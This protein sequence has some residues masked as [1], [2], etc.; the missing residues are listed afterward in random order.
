MKAL[1]IFLALAISLASEARQ[2]ECSGQGITFLVSGTGD[3]LILSLGGEVAPADG[4]LS[5]D[6]VDLIAATRT[7]GELTL[8]AKLGKTSPENYLFF[9]GQR[10]SIYCR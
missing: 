4:L 2:V 7:L 9:R 6:E 1:F 3:K 5:A 8:F 10:I